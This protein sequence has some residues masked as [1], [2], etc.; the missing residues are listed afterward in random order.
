MCFVGEGRSASEKS[1]S[2]ELLGKIVS[3]DSATFDEA[4]AANKGLGSVSFTPEDGGKKKKQKSAK[5]LK[6]RA[7]QEGAQRDDPRLAGKKPLKKK[8]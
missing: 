8:R 7:A 3:V 2:L 6:G 5:K 1:R 4:K